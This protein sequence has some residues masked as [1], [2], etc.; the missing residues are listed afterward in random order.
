M[1]KIWLFIFFFLCLN[2]YGQDYGR[3]A[4]H[5]PTGAFLGFNSDSG[6]YSEELIRKVSGIK[7]RELTQE[8]INAAI[9]TIKQ[10]RLTALKNNYSKKYPIDEIE[11]RYIT[12]EEWLAIKDIWISAL[13]RKAKK[14]KEIKEKALKEKL[15]LTDSEWELIK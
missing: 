15:N 4:F 10:N 12:K 9:A 5:K 11:V 1:K 8:E 6:K 13:V 7:D 2:C 14:E 3:V